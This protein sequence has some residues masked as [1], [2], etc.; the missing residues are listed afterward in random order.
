A[1]IADAKK[2]AIAEKAKWPYTW[3]NEPL[4]PIK[5][6]TV[7]GHLIISH[8]RSAAYA[9]VILGQPNNPGRGGDRG[10]NGGTGAVVDRGSAVYTQ[11]GDYIYYVKADGDGE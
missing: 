9:Y 2:T 4:F 8:D 10:P 7:T 1:I 3:V 6:T 5:R 11:A